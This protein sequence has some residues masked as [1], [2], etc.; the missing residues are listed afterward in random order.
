MAPTIEVGFAEVS[1]SSGN[2]FINFNFST[3][4][5]G[6]LTFFFLFFGTQG[7]ALDGDQENKVQEEALILSIDTG[8][9]SPEMDE[10]LQKND[11]NP[12]DLDSFEMEKKPCRK[13]S[14]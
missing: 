2:S 7:H 12:E 1:F 6:V 13:G 14:C 8:K 10:F 4:L 11:L 9:D 5:V 3:I